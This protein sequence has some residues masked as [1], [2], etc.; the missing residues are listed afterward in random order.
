MLAVPRDMS[1]V[2]LFDPLGRDI[3]PFSEGDGE[4][5]EPIVS[6]I[7]VW[8]LDE[9]LL[10]VEEARLGVLEVFFELVDHRL[11]FRGF[12]PCLAEILLMAAVRSFDEGVDNGA[13][14]GWVQVSGCDGV[15]N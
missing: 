7:P 15:P 6:D 1:I 9:G 3:G 14:R 10:I 12:G 2:E 4:G 13:E 5:G 11:M 8:S